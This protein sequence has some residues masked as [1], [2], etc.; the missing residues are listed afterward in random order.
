MNKSQ[1]NNTMSQKITNNLWKFTGIAILILISLIL[2]ISLFKK[3]RTIIRT[4]IS[5]QNIKLKTIT[6]FDDINLKIHDDVF[7]H[8][9]VKSEYQKSEIVAYLKNNLKKGDTIVEV[10]HDI[11]I[12]TLLIAKLVGQSGRIY[13]YN[14]YVKYVDSINSSAIANG[15]E[16]RIFIQGFGIS[17]H[18]YNGLLVHK[19]NFPLMSGKLENKDYPIPLGYSAMVVKISSIDELLPNL[20]NI[21]LLRINVNGDEAGI[22]DGA[23]NLIKKSDK[24]KILLSFNN[25]TFK[26]YSS[27]QKLLLIGFKI[28]LVQADGF[29]KEITIQELEKITKGYIVLQK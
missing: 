5:N 14:P 21:D 7:S 9:A 20:Q 10:N 26:G 15:F 12:Y 28:H 29:T 22:L 19:N 23:V 6:I 3:H 13:S 27:I 16:S 25:V 8:D 1:K 11:G 4:N 18:T 2:A 17:D 24:I